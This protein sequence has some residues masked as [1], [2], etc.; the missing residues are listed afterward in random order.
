MP[1]LDRLLRPDISSA[2]AET[3][4][5]PDF[6]AIVRRGSQRRRTSTMLVAAAVAVVIAAVAAGSTVVI[7][8]QRTSP[9]PVTPDTPSPTLRTMPS[10]D[11]A[12]DETIQPGAYRI[13]SSSWSAADFTIAFPEGWSVQYGHIYH[14]EPDQELTLESAV[15]DEVFTDACRTEGVPQAVGPGVQDL[16]TALRGQ[17]GSETSAP[18]QTT[19]GGYPATRVD[20]RVPT[21]L[22]LAS[23]RSADD[24]FPGI[25]IWYSEPADNYFV[26][27][28]GA[29]A[30]VYIIDVGG[31]RQVFVAQNRSPGSAE[32][33]A[34]LQTVLDSIRIQP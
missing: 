27:Y 7:G 6:D 12:M 33:R 16:V 30:S 29:V 9:S 10:G 25:Q 19:L 3:T 13:P 20:V 11:G 26:L 2:A 22:D 5:P 28:A 32:A 14:H 17:Q 31:R 1:D 15:V 21:G 23:C 24:G 8:E 34:R 18:R 4:Q